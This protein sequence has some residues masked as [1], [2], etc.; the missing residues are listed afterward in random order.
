MKITKQYLKDLIKEE[1]SNIEHDSV[2]NEEALD[3][4][5]L[6]PSVEKAARDVEAMAKA[7]SPKEEIQQMVI[8][9]VIVK[10]NELIK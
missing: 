5:K 4:A 8:T 1:I 2:L 10:L 3:L 7:I 9:A 6:D